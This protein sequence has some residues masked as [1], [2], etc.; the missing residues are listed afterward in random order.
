MIY[1]DS[2][3]ELGALSDWTRR[4]KLEM[5]MLSLIMIQLTAMLKSKDCLL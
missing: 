1:L 2:G 4:T 5:D 3:S